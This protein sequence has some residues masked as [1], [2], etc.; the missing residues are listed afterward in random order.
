MALIGVRSYT[1]TKV[2]NAGGDE[3]RCVDDFT[4]FYYHPRGT[5][6]EIAPG[7]ADADMSPGN[8]TPRHVLLTGPGHGYNMRI[9][10]EK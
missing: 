2:D 1:E 8:V 7:A 9:E 5:G 4:G 3:P 10:R 6:G